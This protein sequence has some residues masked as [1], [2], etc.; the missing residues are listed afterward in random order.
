[1]GILF[2]LFVALI[3]YTYAGYPFLLGLL[4]L[5]WH[6]PVPTDSGATPSFTMLIAA[7]NE[8][9]VIA[10]KLD[11]CLS[12]DY[13][14]EK[15]QILVAAD[16]SDDQTASIVRGY[17]SQGVELSYTS[18]RGGK[19]SAINRALP[20]AR[21]EIVVFSDANNM[22]GTDALRKLAAPFA[23]PTIGAVSGAK[24]IVRLDGVLGEAEGMYWRY[25][26]FIKKCETRLGSV[27]GAAGEI[28]AIRRELFKPPPERIIN[29]D[30]YMSAEL[31]KRGYRVVYVADARTYERV[32]PTA[33]DEIVRR[34]RIVAGRYQALALSREMLPFNR[35]LIVWEYLSHKFLRPLVPFAMIGALL[36]NLAA[37]VWP[38]QVEGGLLTQV[39]FLARP[40][41]LIGIGVQASFYL[42]AVVGNILPK[43]GLGGN[44][45][46]LPTFLVN[47]NYSALAGLYRFLTGKQTVLWE[48]AARAEVV[49]PG[50]TDQPGGEPS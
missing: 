6:K 38:P 23:D 24:S 48:R 33:M 13:P 49:T 18:E 20:K 36:A 29:D 2:W 47:S 7:Y 43:Q 34:T 30:F 19:M 5:V 4:S 17:A 35:P 28:F 32:S 9:D 25:E 44:L 45:L 21:G 26:S 40:I 50:G 14:A 31:I 27:I 8:E 41:N 3:I 11:N 15:L 10:R 37:V 12:L 16:G 39:L 1:L 46:Y 42:A 22:Y